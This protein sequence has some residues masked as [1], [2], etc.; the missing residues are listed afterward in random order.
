MLKLIDFDTCATCP[1]L[2]TGD[3][4]RGQAGT[5][6]YMSPEMFDSI[7]DTGNAY[8]TKTDLWSTGVTLFKMLCGKEPF[9]APPFVMQV[10]ADSEDGAEFLEEDWVLDIRSGNYSFSDEVWSTISQRAKDLV[11]QLLTIQPHRRPTAMQAMG[12][13]WIKG[14]HDERVKPSIVGHGIG[15]DVLNALVSFCE[16][17][18]G[19]RY[20]LQ[21]LC[22]S[23]MDFEVQLQW[24]LPIFSVFDRK[25]IGCVDLEDF[26]AALHDLQAEI[27]TSQ[28]AHLFDRLLGCFG[29]KV[30]SSERRSLQYSE[31]MAAVLPIITMPAFVQGVTDGH[32]I[33]LSVLDIEHDLR[34]AF[35]LDATCKHR[36]LS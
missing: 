7:Q 3:M 23:K 16:V 24:I 9:T 26:T 17:S 28:C 35:N 33:G 13:L 30:G 10:P 14:Q 12:H 2:D 25:A 18:D 1:D 31:F 5:P 15:S 36:R 34:S 8:C 6:C 20:S 11:K 4:L 32:G 27:T 21:K 22:Y 19:L 29:K